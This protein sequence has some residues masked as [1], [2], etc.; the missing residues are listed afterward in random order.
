[1]SLEL[2]KKEFQAC[3]GEMRRLEKDLLPELKKQAQEIRQHGQCIDTTA[4]K[5]GG[6]EE[7]HEAL[8]REIKQITQDVAK[9]LDDLEIKSQRKFDVPEPRYGYKS[10]AQTFSN[11]DAYARYKE[12]NYPQNFHADVPLQS[13]KRYAG[14]YDPQMAWPGMERKDLSGATNQQLREVLSI[15]LIP[16]IIYNPLRPNRV[17]DLLPTYTTSDSVIKYAVETVYMINAAVTQ[18]TATKPQ[19]NLTFAAAEVTCQTIAHWIP[20]PRQILMDIDTLPEYLDVRLTQGLKMVEDTELLY[21]TG[22]GGDLQGIMTAPNVQSYKWS[23][24]TG[25]GTGG[26]VDTRIDALRRAMTKVRLA[27]YPV[28]GIVIHL[29]DWETIETQKNTQGLYVWVNVATGTGPMLWKVPVVETNAIQVGEALVGNF[30]LAAAVYDREEANLRMTD[31]HGN[32][33]ITNMMVLL[34]E[35]RLAVVVYRPQSLCVCLFDTPP[36][37]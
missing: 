17:R 29:T 34:V 18:E 3:A 2:I 20:V 12:S 26:Q 24:G 35:E 30:N 37:S 23:Q 27:Y 10:L 32:F 6:M 33:F 36:A 8:E 31:S 13:L 15:D 9:R 11:S 22:T 14:M 19:S 25:H 21:G 1:M 5:I 28:T 16:Q 7:K 4:R